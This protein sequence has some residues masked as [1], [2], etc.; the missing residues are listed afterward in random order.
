MCSKTD[1]AHFTFFWENE[2]NEKFFQRLLNELHQILPFN[3]KN[4][5]DFLQYFYIIMCSFRISIDWRKKKSKNTKI[6]FVGFWTDAPHLLS[7]FR[8]VYWIFKNFI[9]KSVFS[10]RREWYKKHR[11]TDQSLRESYR[12][13]FLALSVH[14]KSNEKVMENNLKT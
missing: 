8:N 4:F 14:F 3:F 9:W 2:K 7:L 12:C 13:S 1:K 11:V 6:G 10:R 5:L